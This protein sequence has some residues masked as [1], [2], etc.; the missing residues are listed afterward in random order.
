MTCFDVSI[1]FYMSLHLFDSFLS[2]G[3]RLVVH[4][5]SV[6]S[7]DLPDVLHFSECTITI[8]II[9]IFYSCEVFSPLFWY[10]LMMLLVRYF[11]CFLKRSCILT[12]GFLVGGTAPSS[13]LLLLLLL[14]L[15][16][17]LSAVCGLY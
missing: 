16:P 5:P 7:S 11:N 1:A 14:S 13:S 6:R 17:I 12:Q 15:E 2:V 4:T 9:I 3:E 8:G 10:F